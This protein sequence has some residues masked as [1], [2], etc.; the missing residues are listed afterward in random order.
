MNNECTYIL[1]YTIYDPQSNKVLDPTE[2][3]LPYGLTVDEHLD[4]ITHQIGPDGS[5]D[6]ESHGSTQVEF[7]V[8]DPS[9]DLLLSM[10]NTIRENPT[11]SFYG[12][13]IVFSDVFSDVIEIGVEDVKE[14]EYE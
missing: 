1:S 3:F 5:V 13:R 2:T 12:Y 10:K 6:W 4:E 8:Y 14:P 9:N 7:T 11:H